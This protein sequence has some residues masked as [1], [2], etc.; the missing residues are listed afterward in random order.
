MTGLPGR[1][2][3]VCMWTI[4][5]RV[6]HA[7]IKNTDFEV[8]HQVSSPISPWEQWEPTILTSVPGDSCQARSTRRNAL[9]LPGV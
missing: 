9:E 4:Y 6:T 2:S 1:G 7:A 8:L 5:I 3:P